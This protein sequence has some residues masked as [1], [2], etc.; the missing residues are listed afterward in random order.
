MAN[1]KRGSQEKSGKSTISVKLSKEMKAD[2]EK[3]IEKRVSSIEKQL[4]K[5]NRSSS[6]GSGSKGNGQKNAGKTQ[7]VAAK[8]T[9]DKGK[10]KSTQRNEDAE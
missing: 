4:E 9:T 3:M 10:R 2:I 7:S 8:K 5:L 1:A 6:K